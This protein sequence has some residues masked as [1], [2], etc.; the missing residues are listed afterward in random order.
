MWSSIM[1]SLG[2][3]S[4]NFDD[5]FFWQRLAE[6]SGLDSRKPQ[7]DGIGDNN[8]QPDNFQ[9]DNAHPD[10]W[11]VFQM[12]YTFLFYNSNFIIKYLCFNSYQCVEPRVVELLR[13]Y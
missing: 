4:L 10:N 11:N 8:A 3:I 5:G 13:I 1:L 2:P 12:W 9:P 6:S 7:D